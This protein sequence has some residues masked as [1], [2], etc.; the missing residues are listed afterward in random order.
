MTTTG[1]QALILGSGSPRR[2]ELLTKLDIAFDVITPGIDEPAEATVDE[3]A[4]AKFDS[5][6]SRYPGRTILTA[7]TLVV[8]NG[9]QLGKPDDADHAKA[10]LSACSGNRVNVVSSLCIGQG[11]HVESRR[12]ESQVQLRVLAPAEIDRYVATGAASDKAGALALQDEAAHFVDYA[13]TLSAVDCDAGACFSNVVGLPMCAV[14]DVLGVPA[15]PRW[16]RWPVRG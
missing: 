11:H 10:M 14:A 2:A 3:I 13:A 8:L 4:R 16:C 1:S 5:L 15:D 7:D 6:S 9:G 12:V